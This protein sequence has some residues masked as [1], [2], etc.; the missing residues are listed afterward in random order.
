MKKNT[1]RV[2]T[3]KQSIDILDVL[4]VLAKKK[5][6][7]L[8][9]TFF[10]TVAVIIYS[11]LVPKYWH[12]HVSFTSVGQDKTSLAGAQALLSGFGT[13]LSTTE[14]NHIIIL[15]SRGF[16]EK[17]INDFDLVEYFEIVDDDS[18]AVMHLAIKQ[19]HEDV[20]SISIDDD[21]GMITIGVET[22][23]RYLSSRIANAYYDMLERYTLDSKMSKGRERRTFLEKRIE[24]LESD[25]K[26]YSAELETFQR[27]TNLLDLKAQQEAII[28]VYSD[29]AAA[30]IEAEIELEY[31][32]R[33]LSGEN[34]LI[35]GLQ[36]K[37]RVLNNQIKQME[38]GDSELKPQYL[39]NLDDIPN[40]A[41]RFMQL[42]LNLEIQKKVIEFIYPQFEQ[43]KLDELSDISTLE[44][45]DRAVPAGIRSRP[46]R[47]RMVILGFLA[48]FLIASLLGYTH[49]VLTQTA[50]KDKINELFHQLFG[51]SAK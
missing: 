48:T 17:I 47:A 28:G 29:I 24:T 37:V 20:L 11:L 3:E 16:S 1:G 25:F 41:N 6:F 50:R 46:K 40:L 43:A 44:L 13:T 26:H 14:L 49:E 21:S 15:R 51:R 33:Y 18:L 9:T 42:T 45:I 8:L 36:E 35:S 5:S 19:L 4:I 22:K 30:K 31:A 32:Q 23:D 2:M 7:I 39:V 10:V 27:E 34:H 12:S 38:T